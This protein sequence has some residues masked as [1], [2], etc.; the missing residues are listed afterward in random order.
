LFLHRFLLLFFFLLI[1][2]EWACP[3]NLSETDDPM[4]TKLHRK[5]DPHLKRC[6]QL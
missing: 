3:A 2:S 6:T 4:F 1:F 5:V